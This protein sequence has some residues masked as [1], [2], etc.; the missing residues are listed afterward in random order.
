MRV[1][2]LGRG[3][4]AAMEQWQVPRAVHEPGRIVTDLAAPLVVGGD[5]LAEIAVLR[6]QP[7]LAGP[8]AS[9][10]WVSP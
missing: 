2:G 5:C 8:V 10:R 7:E 1:T 4:S 6:E 9:D 3:L